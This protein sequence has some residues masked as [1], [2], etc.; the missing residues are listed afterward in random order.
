MSDISYRIKS[1]DSNIE[2][3]NYKEAKRIAKRLCRETGSAIIEKISEK[4]GMV[5]DEEY[6]DNNY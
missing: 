4:L 2:T 3:S 6:V 1:N 5:I